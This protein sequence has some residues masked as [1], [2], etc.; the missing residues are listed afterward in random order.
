VELKTDMRGWI[1][2]QAEEAC[3]LL[4]SAHLQEAR[5][6]FDYL[7]DSAQSLVQSAAFN[8]VPELI[9][10]LL[11]QAEK[12]L[13][14]IL[15]V[16]RHFQTMA[17]KLH[18]AE[19]SLSLI[20]SF[21]L[22]LLKTD[23]KGSSQALHTAMSVIVD[24]VSSFLGP[25]HMQSVALR[26]DFPGC[27]KKPRSSL[28]SLLDNSDRENGIS[29]PTSIE[30]LRAMAY[31]IFVENSDIEDAFVI[32]AK[33]LERTRQAP[34]AHSRELGLLTALSIQIDATLRSRQYE[35][36]KQVI[37]Q[38]LVIV[39]KL[40]ALDSLHTAA[41]LSRL[42]DRLMQLGRQDEAQFARS[43]QLTLVQSNVG[44]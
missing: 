32:A 25:L 42:E 11:E 44:S 24:G 29:S 34:N 33:I 13:P 39:S 40:D 20:L 27:T 8:L 36:A 15:A 22:G 9:I 19:H 26:V 43:H 31:N 16:L 30:C 3:D 12:H 2:S 41:L 5:L 23:P 35:Q 18:G 1:L 14:F 17:L 37:H 4:D 21:I 7:C 28:R 38:L 6:R 10:L